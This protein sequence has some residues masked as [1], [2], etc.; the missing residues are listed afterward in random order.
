MEE[1]QQYINTQSL[2]LT[3]TTA[4][5]GYGSVLTLNSYYD[6]NQMF[7]IM[8]TSVDGSSAPTGKASKFCITSTAIEVSMK[9]QFQ[10]NAIVDIYEII[11]R[12]DTATTVS[13]CFGNGMVDQNSS[14][15]DTTVGVTFFESNL[16]CSLYKI[17]RKTRY[18]L[19]PGA[20]EIFTARSKKRIMIDWERI[21]SVGT[22]PTQVYRGKSKIYMAIIRGE[23]T[24]D[25]NA[26]ICTAPSKVDFVTTEIYRFT[27]TPNNMVIT[28]AVNTALGP[29]GTNPVISLLEPTGAVVSGPTGA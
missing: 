28:T 24:D 12:Q 3:A 6:L 15:T 14:G 11:P 21:A 13:A 1:S 9:N 20:T 8:G 19:A 10:T 23:P 17:L 29:T 22:S 5:Q 27:Y 7:T 16:L 18:L 26:R 4:H 2:S 25:G